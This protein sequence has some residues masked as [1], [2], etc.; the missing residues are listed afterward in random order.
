[1]PFE[2]PNKF[3]FNSLLFCLSHSVFFSLLT[4]HYS[5]S[6]IHPSFD[7]D[8]TIF[9]S[10]FFFIFDNSNRVCTCVCVTWV[11][12][13]VRFIATSFYI[14]ALKKRATKRYEMKWSKIDN[15]KERKRLQRISIIH[16][17]RLGHCFCHSVSLILYF[18][19]SFWRAHIW[20]TFAFR[21]LL[22]MRIV[23]RNNSIMNL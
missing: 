11:F 7:F 21:G 20:H 9:F 12:V 10:I 16:L 6:L 19:S 5:Y 8:F 3:V 2:N 22:L 18:V 13:E 4:T 23:D 14:F 1:M 15:E 17:V